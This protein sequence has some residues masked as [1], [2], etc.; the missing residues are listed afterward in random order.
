MITLGPVFQWFIS[1]GN[2]ASSF[3]T[4]RKPDIFVRFTNGIKGYKKYFYKKHFS[5]VTI[6]SRCFQMVKN[7]LASHL[8]NRHLFPVFELLD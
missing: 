4:I 7:K 2:Q 5:L 8:K 1:A 6:V 3:W